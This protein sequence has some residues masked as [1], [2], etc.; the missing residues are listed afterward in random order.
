MPIH[1]NTNLYEI[2]I[3]YDLAH[4]EEGQIEPKIIGITESLIFSAGHFVI[5]FIQNL[6]EYDT[7]EYLKDNKNIYQE[8]AH[9]DNSVYG[10]FVRISKKSSTKK[11]DLDFGK[12]KKFEWQKSKLKKKENLIH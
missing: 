12:G 6:W 3:I 1:A 11:L 4:L 10:N 8:N 9:I 7:E 2:K 5:K